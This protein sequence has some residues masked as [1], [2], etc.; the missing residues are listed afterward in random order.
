MQVKKRQIT[1]AL[2]VA[3]RDIIEHFRV[4]HVA[5]N[6]FTKKRGAGARPVL[7]LDAGQVGK[8]PFTTLL[9]RMDL[10]L[11]RMRLVL[12]AKQSHANMRV[13]MHLL[14][15]WVPQFDRLLS[16]VLRLLNDRVSMM[17]RSRRG[18]DMTAAAL[19]E[20]FSLH[21]DLSSCACVL[22]NALDVLLRHAGPATA[23]RPQPPLS[24][25]AKLLVRKIS[26]ILHKVLPV[27][28]VRVESHV[29]QRVTEAAAAVLH[30]Q[31]GRDTGGRIASSPCS[32][33]VSSVQGGVLAAMMTTLATSSCTTSKCRR[34]L[35]RV[36]LGGC[37]ASLLT[38]VLQQGRR[39]DERAVLRL[40]AD[41][42]AL[43]AGAAQY[44]AAAGL[45][46]G[47]L[48]AHGQVSWCRANEVLKLL[49]SDTAG[50]EGGGARALLSAA[51]QH[52]WSSLGRRRG[53][54]VARAR[55]WGCCCSCA[56]RSAVVSI[57]PVLL[58][59]DV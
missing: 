23:S 44:R 55:L 15:P 53:C 30:Q 17:W 26:F 48:V 31:G 3:T 39:L 9:A 22:N 29:A 51:E 28:V 2:N 7:V 13:Q 1:S 36:V 57:A 21:Q 5:L 35:L 45:P 52:A 41:L 33:A 59:E 20:S 27:M 54:K 18:D 12:S 6:H 10:F 58:T 25:A 14:S 11:A 4:L 8:E 32:R 50:I 49:L 37:C 46:P 42:Q 38:S 56:K 43:L 16:N 34:R 40:H 19:D 47:A 24:V